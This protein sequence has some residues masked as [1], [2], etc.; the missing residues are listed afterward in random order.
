MHLIKSKMRVF[1]L[2]SLV[3]SLTSPNGGCPD[4]SIQVIDEIFLEAPSYPAVPS[5]S[6]TK[7]YGE[8]LW[9][10]DDA[11]DF[12]AIR[13]QLIQLRATSET[14]PTTL[15]LIQKLNE[16]YPQLE[17]IVT[18]IEDRSQISFPTLSVSDTASYSTIPSRVEY[19]RYGIH[20]LKP[21]ASLN[22]SHVASHQESFRDTFKNFKQAIGYFLPTGSVI[23]GSTRVNQGKPKIFL[24]DF[25]K[26][27]TVYHEMTHY[28][29][30]IQRQMA[31][32]DYPT[33]DKDPFGYRLAHLG[34]E[35]NNYK[36]LYEMR[37]ELGLSADEISHQV[38]AHGRYLS[39][40]KEHFKKNPD[41]L[42]PALN[43][44]LQKAQEFQA[45]AEN[46]S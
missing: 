15:E 41:R 23:H 39:L 22:P 11:S 29:L 28:F 36:N 34:E 12:S 25:A 21:Q 24:K 4:P 33:P 8:V 45:S 44:Q 18:D 1:I 13:N 30:W 31:G 32:V 20:F 43:A 42:T 5:S 17:T 37:N 6:Q 35:M 26:P 19:E 16:K 2:F 10:Q 40:M 7:H 3:A 9:N 46:A 38:E 14:P 27:M